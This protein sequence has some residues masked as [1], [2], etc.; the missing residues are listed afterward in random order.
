MIEKVNIENKYNQIL[1][2]EDSPTQSEQLKFILEKNNYSV[3]IAKDGKEAL[4]LVAENKPSLIISDIIMPGMDGYELCK[5][6]KSDECTMD[7]PVILLTSLSHSE[8]VL[9]GISCGADNFITKPYHEDYLISHV[10]QI[11][12]NK[13]INQNERVRVGVE[14]M[15]GG[16]RRFITS[17]QQQ[18]LTLLISTYEA[19]VQRNDELVQT[20]DSLKKL[21]EHLEELVDKRTA[22][23]ST[24]IKVR[25]L[26]EERIIKINR[27]YQL[28]S[29]INRTIVKADD[30]N[31]L[32]NEIC[33]IS[34]NIG[35]YKMVWIGLVDE[36]DN[37][38]KP[39]VWNGDSSGYIDDL[40][41]PLNKNEEELGTAGRA[42]KE[43]RFIICNDI[44]SDKLIGVRL[45]KALVKNFHSALSFPLR[46][47]GSAFGVISFYSDQKNFFD[48][49]EVKLL[50][51][52][53]IDVSFSIHTIEEEA[54]KKLTQVELKNNQ[55]RLQMS[56]AAAST[57]I[58]EWDVR[59][60]TVF[61]SEEC[62]KIIGRKETDNTIE[63]FLN[64]ILSEDLEMVNS[65]I[66]K[67]MVDKI[68]FDFEFRITS[69]DGKI[70]WLHDKGKSEFDEL[71]IT[72]RMLG[73]VNDITE[74]K[75]AEANL[76]TSET[77][78][79]RLFESAKDGI[80]ILDAETGKINDV[81]LFLIELL[82]LSKEQFI[83][84]SIWEI[85]FSKDITDNRDKFLEL[86]QNKYIRYENL[87]LETEDGRKVNVEF[88]SN[89]YLVNNHKV[90]QCNIRDIT[91]RKRIEKNLVESE[92]K[93]R[94]LITQSPDGIFIVDLSGSFL[95][96]N[97]AMCDTLKYS[98]KEFLSMTIW[99][100]ISQKYLS[101]QQ[102]R[103]S[104][105]IKGEAKLEAAEYEVKGKDGV[106][107]FIEVLSIPYYKDNQIIGF[108][109]IA[110]NITDRKKAEELL[111][112]EQNLLLMLLNN[113]PDRIYFKDQE[114]RFI[115]ISKAQAGKF[116]L[117]DPSEA[118]GKTDFD[119]FTEE[120]ARPAFDDEM[121]IIRSGKQMVG[122]EEKETWP[123]GSVT[124]VLTNKVPFRN[125]KGEIIGTFGISTDIT[126]R[127]RFEESL[128][129]QKEE[130]ETI[131]NL[132]PSQIW[133][134]DTR[135][136]FI[137]VNRQGCADIGMTSDQIEGHSA[138]E[139]FPS[140]A[141]QYF[142]DD[143]EVINTGKPKLGII[144]KINTINGELRWVL[145]DK[146]PVFGKDGK[147][148]GLIAVV[149]DITEKKHAEEEIAMLAH[150]LRSINECVS[151]TNLEDQ[152]LFVNESFVKTYGYTLSE[153]IGKSINIVRSP[154]NLPEI[155]NEIF[156][157][158]MHGGWQ[159][160]LINK[161]KD[162]TEFPIFLS[163]TILND[164]NGNPL[165]LIGVATDITER[166]HADEELQ[167]KTAFL[168]ALVNS[169]IDGILV[170]DNHE[171]KIL[172]NQRCIDLWKVPQNIVEQNDDAVQVQYVMNRTI[173]PE[174]FVE[175]VRYMY[176]HPNEISHDEI[177]FKDGM[178]LERY[179][180]PVLGQDGANYGRI[181]T[182]REITERKLR[183]EEITMLA[184]A[185]R[186]VKECVSI[187]DLEDNI[188][189]VNETFI[190][191]YGYRLDELIGN[192]IELVRSQNNPSELVEKILPATKLGEWQ[193]ELWNKRKDESE[194]RV[195]LSTTLI[196]N[197]DNKP[198]GMIGVAVDITEFKRTGEELIR[199]KEKA[200]ESDRLKSEFL[201]QMSH[202]IRTP[203]NAIVGNTDYLSESIGKDKDADTRSCFD[204]IDQA[205][206]RIIR[207]VDLILNVA[208][209]QTSGYKPVFDKFDL[210]AD[211]L[212]I[213][214][215]EYKLSA[216]LKGL[217]FTYICNE[218][219]TYVT[220]D[221]YS[222]MQIFGN[223][224]DNAIKY[225]KKGK[226]E[227]L[228]NKNETG[229]IIV[230]IKDTG[231][232]MSNEFLPKLF[233]AFTQ[234]EQGYSRSY[235]GNGLGLSLVKKYC[236]LNDI[237]IEVESKKNEGST[238]RIIFTK[239]A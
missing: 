112:Y 61:W 34:I 24:E 183:E 14:I 71:G 140:F 181:W 216:K 170:I 191:T 107:H 145:S 29:N 133:F 81:N 33:N 45:R 159:G 66:E 180:A 52:L 13:K 198:I 91:E 109:G 207:T 17:S 60:N 146:V 144:E 110:R 63:G 31:W 53:A 92:E 39:L 160:E 46:K 177:E 214:Y 203:L 156:P 101:M 9:E 50:D 21:N 106:V 38:I 200:E 22:E 23:L 235:D 147:V 37:T 135:N 153:L 111:T 151:I 44:E 55:E 11:L 65:K 8:D 233:Q 1:I 213:L 10:V 90:I 152:L 231:I 167:W 105:I 88:V 15:F 194:F 54:Q 5:K 137:R 224:I 161:K 51:E 205:S 210:D 150:S 190:Q 116:G 82:G 175:K 193:G 228:L 80:L 121:E 25:K 176:D 154:K 143:L 173:N 131:F 201:A 209:L 196:R 83:G 113:T 47:N 221:E 32:F 212:S 40:V 123:D 62:L 186:S 68:P 126:E 77:S 67:S 139:L 85:G 20:Q 184:Q 97:K 134:K 103:L 208:E 128:K 132:V 220:A 94:T 69:S 199:A 89:V 136:N 35:L 206:K 165:G 114:S 202:E 119:F 232:G 19:A 98:E 79:R 168:E 120:H 222:I 49:Q 169:S 36:K 56:L 215:Q 30:T 3:I 217:E 127:K 84:K 178:F 4:K 225:T 239:K 204:G 149:Q 59:T 104:A 117:N 48:E 230:E 172:Q 95:S 28:L 78:Y 99:E 162:G 118:I 57:G 27:V 86:Q 195:F 129:K 74:R 227:I 171:K 236:E 6:I 223:I 12:A 72:I 237:L 76:I 124:W 219:H 96:V 70:I 93:F 185:L 197:K 64:L 138:E 141:V 174:Q 87:P 158:T 192:N 238:F 234:E 130:F 108:Q 164:N 42:I 102:K 43:N 148:T 166:K 73:T 226:V 163:T 122:L 182:F 16:K 7:I 211:I 115:R 188:I 58:W 142:K 41:I 179:S 229:D 218:K 189:F 2:A 187:T 155:T 75:L 157:A 26:A 100:I 18:M 125:I